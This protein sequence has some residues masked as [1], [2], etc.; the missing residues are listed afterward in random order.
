M[1]TTPQMECAA[2]SGTATSARNIRLARPKTGKTTRV[3]RSDLENR[4]RRPAISTS[5]S[6]RNGLVWVGNM[7]QGSLV[8]FDP[9]PMKFQSCGR[10]GIPD[11][12]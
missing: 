5:G 11:P 9:R 1:P 6:D 2:M 10:A 8:M 12:Q 7:M 3:F 4:A